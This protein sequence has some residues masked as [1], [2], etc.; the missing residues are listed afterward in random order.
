MHSIRHRYW[1]FILD[2]SIL[3]TRAA[4]RLYLLAWHKVYSGDGL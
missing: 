3:L 1:T 4:Y 2:L